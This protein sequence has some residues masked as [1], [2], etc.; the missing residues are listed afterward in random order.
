MKKLITILLALFVCLPGSAFHDMLIILLIAWMWRKEW[1]P[2]LNERWKYASKTG[3]GGMV[4]LTLVLMPR[5][6]ALPAD[7]VQLVYF[8]DKGKQVA[9]PLSHWIWNLIIPEET[10]TAVAS[11]FPL[12]PLRSALPL[13]E[14]ILKDYDIELKSGG[15]FKVGA[16]YRAN[17][18]ALESPMSGL[19]TQG[20]QEFFGDDKRSAYIIRPRNYDKDKQYPVLFFAHG[21]LGNW[22]LYTGLLRN[23]ENH[24]VVC[25]GTEDYSGI[26]SS[27]HI[28][29]I[30]TLYL[31][32]LEKKGYKIDRS[33]I[34]LMGL[35]NGGSAVDM[36]Y[37]GFT[38]QFKNLIY[39]STGVNN[40]H[41]TNAK[42]M[43]IGGGIDHCAPS[44]RNGMQRLRA[45]RQKSAFLF[46]EEDTHLKFIS[47]MEGCID[48][49][50]REL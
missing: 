28:S 15:L 26:F 32:M 30:K 27:Q 11:I 40:F 12:T 35:S 25:M 21:Y 24:I 16:P 13:G 48:F 7:R 23:I 38:N 19:V 46:D 22:K 31:P 34:S 14:G 1:M 44:M 10:M 43:I 45:N 2:I 18:F 20:F 5:P 29:E 36:A 37:S 49:L 47:D 9:P 6:F 39:V 50:N 3:W 17:N 33:A 42:V 4:A 41:H 8:N